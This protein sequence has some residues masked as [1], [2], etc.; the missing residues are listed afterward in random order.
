MGD[1]PFRPG[2]RVRIVSGVFAGM[3]GVV[4]SHAEAV[5]RCP[6]APANPEVDRGEA[7]WVV[8]RIFNQE[9]PIVQSA[10]QLAAE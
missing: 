5:A 1:A 8:A 9:L 2:D 3:S 7:F 10:D 6:D 4:I